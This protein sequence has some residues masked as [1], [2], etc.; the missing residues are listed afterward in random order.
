METLYH[1][2]S[3]N[4]FHSIIK[5]KAIWLSSLSLSNDSLEGKIVSEVIS[6]LA[7]EEKL[8]PATIKRLKEY[9]GYLEQSIDGLGFCLSE[10]SDLLSQWRG[11]ANDATGFSIGFSK[12][13]LEE[14]AGEYKT[15]KQTNGFRIQ[16]VEYDQVKHIELV[17]PTFKKIK[18]QIANGAFQIPGLRGILDTRTDEE[19]EEE[20]K[21]IK[22]ASKSLSIQVLM[23]YEQLFRLKSHAFKEE[24]EWRLLSPRLQSGDDNCKY[25]ATHNSLIPYRSYK[26]G[27]SAFNPIVEVIIGPKNMT[28]SNVVE[29]FLISNGFTDVKVVKSKASYR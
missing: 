16:Q 10:E 23:L 19:F 26:I 13:Y 7:N 24:K 1:Y 4:T 8:D 12:N 29:G 2:C 18:E 21:K 9:I 17:K 20:T 11:Y 3:V 28:P 6:H 25:R 27:K 22:A 15:N 14:L 5:G